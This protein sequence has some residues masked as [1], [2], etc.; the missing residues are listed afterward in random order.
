VLGIVDQNFS[1][2]ASYGVHALQ[3]PADLKQI[4]DPIPQQ[5]TGTQILLPNE[6]LPQNQLQQST[7]DLQRLG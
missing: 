1:G 4:Q 6:E 5:V 7:A 3:N 2:T